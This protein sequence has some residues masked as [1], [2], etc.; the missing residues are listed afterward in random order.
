MAPTSHYGQR[1]A[2]RR[3]LGAGRLGEV[4]ESLH[5]EGFFERVVAIKRLTALT[6]DH[7]L[8]WRIFEEDVR[9]AAMLTHA[10]IVR[11]LDVGEEDGVPFL[12]M[13][14]VVGCDLRGLGEAT[15]RVARPIPLEVG[16]GIVLQVLEGLRYAHRLLDAAGQCAVLVHRGVSPSNVLVSIDGVASVTDFSLP[17]AEAALLDDLTEEPQPN[18]L[19]YMA[20]EVLLDEGVDERA[21]IYSVGVLLYELT[22][23]QRLLRG[24]DFRTIL[25]S[26]AQPVAPPTF[27]RSGYPAD[28]ELIV[29]RALERYPEDRQASAEVMLEDLE[30]FVE[31]AGLRVTRMRVARFVADVIGLPPALSADLS[32]DDERVRVEEALL[33]SEEDELDFDASGASEE[34]ELDFDAPLEGPVA[35]RDEVSVAGRDEGPVAGRDVTEDASISFAGEAPSPLRDENGGATASS[36]SA[37]A[38]RLGL[39]RPLENT[40]MV[41][42]DLVEEEEDIEASEAEILMAPKGFLDQMRARTAAQQRR[43]WTEGAQGGDAVAS[44]VSSGEEGENSDDRGEEQHNI[45]G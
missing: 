42:D 36:E 33:G 25:R 19:A 22:L 1:Y 3:E 35:G 4:H 7:A 16:V 27:L 5:G 6:R 45:S 10:N 32:S 21:D 23:G 12:V 9:R 17:R 34:D 30:R 28:L 37:T 31:N 13:D 38:V 8:A 15:T 14:R 24:L 43:S 39:P 41:T 44:P 40:V 18:K 20:P 26:L 2:L 11:L 29:M